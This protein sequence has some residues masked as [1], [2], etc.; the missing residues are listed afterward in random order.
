[1]TKFRLG[2]EEFLV[3]SEPA[4]GALAVSGLSASECEVVGLVV[5]GFS[6]EQIA[7]ERGVRYRTVAN[8]LASVYRKLGVSSRVELIAHLHGLARGRK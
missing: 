6:N 4:S 5:K 8:Q 2:A 7:R 1:V 3:L